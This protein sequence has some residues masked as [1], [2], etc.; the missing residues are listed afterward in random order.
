[1]EINSTLAGAIIT[2]KGYGAPETIEI[3]DRSLELSREV[4]EPDLVAPMLY[5]Q[6]VHRFAKG[7]GKAT[8]LER[9]K[10]LLDY[11]LEKKATG[12]TMIGHRVYGASLG[13]QGNLI[14]AEKHLRLSIDLYQPEQHGALTY[15][16]GQNSKAGAMAFLATTAHLRGHCDEAVS[17]AEEAMDTARGSNHVNSV[18]YTLVYGMIRLCVFR[19][20]LEG[21]ART[22]NELLTIAQEH[23]LP[24][25]EGYAHSYIG[26]VLTAGGRHGDAIASIERGLA[27][28]DKTKTHLD[29]PMILGF[30]TEA[31]IGNSDS[32]SAL[33]SVE[34][35][36]NA[37]SNERL[38]EPELL[39]LKGNCSLLATDNE[40]QAKAE[41]YYLAA[42]K[43]NRAHGAK[44][45]ELRTA[46]DL[47][48]LWIDSGKTEGA[49]PLLQSAFSGIIG[50]DGLPEVM[51]AQALLKQA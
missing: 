49:V 15:K 50:G 6:W 3:F 26:W 45:W 32:D 18:A 19:G 25:W 21:A 8:V 12:P 4:D 42:L 24:F 51:A 33:N 14:D 11:G 28:M 41:E 40:G 2:T 10:T 9:A 22:A 38:F 34:A 20:D 37:I 43:I 30:L 46:V 27:W 39:R 48:T 36:L 7:A 47:A 16:Y 29:R 5:G 35:A 17:L 44:I 13:Y 1:L 23:R 31:H